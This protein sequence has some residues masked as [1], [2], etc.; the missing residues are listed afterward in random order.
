MI[1]NYTWESFYIINIPQNWNAMFEIGN[2]KHWL[3]RLFRSNTSISIV[4][5]TKSTKV[6]FLGSNLIEYK[7]VEANEI[8]EEPRVKLKTEWTE[9][10]TSRL[11][12]EKLL[13]G[14]SGNYS[15]V[16]T[17]AE[18]ASVNVHVINGKIFYK[19][20]FISILS[21]YTSLSDPLW[22]LWNSILIYHY[23]ICSI[24]L[25]ISCIRHL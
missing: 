12:I 10:L 13:P 25:S 18:P 2:Y 7:E 8:E 9:Q 21:Y 16:P 11:I 1:K 15:C 4:L 20:E 22:N 24:L 17:M 23:C 3:H 5:E 19:K 14:D 6:I